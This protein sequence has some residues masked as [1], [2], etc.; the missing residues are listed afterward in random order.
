M[1]ISRCWLSVAVCLCAFLPKALSST[2]KMH[3]LIHPITQCFTHDVLCFD[4]WTAP[5]LPHIFFLTM[6][7]VEVDLGFIQ[8]KNIFQNCVGLFNTLQITLDPFIYFYFFFAC[9]VWQCSNENCCL[10]AKKW[11]K[12][13]KGL[14]IGLTSQGAWELQ[15]TSTYS[16]YLTV[17]GIKYE[18]H[19][20]C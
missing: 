19:I 7:L 3:P 8:S 16:Q 4:S 11:P 13:K 9:P 18:T 1:D 17:C 12:K 14:A 15:S 10:K 6:I 2:S 20:W 5:C